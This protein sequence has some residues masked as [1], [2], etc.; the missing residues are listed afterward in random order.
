MDSASPPNLQ[1]KVPD[2]EN[3]LELVMIVSQAGDD[4]ALRYCLLLVDENFTEMAIYR[5]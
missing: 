3:A 2:T 4:I 1:M 5:D